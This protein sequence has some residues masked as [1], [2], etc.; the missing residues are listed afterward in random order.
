MQ[1]YKLF[2]SLQYKVVEKIIQISL[3]FV[4]FAILYP[5]PLIKGSVVHFLFCLQ[6]ARIETQIKTPTLF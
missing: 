3:F 4:K 5:I 2:G 1:I 6:E